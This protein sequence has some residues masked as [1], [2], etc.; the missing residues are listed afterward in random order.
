MKSIPAMVAL[1]AAA[2]FL[3]EFPF[4]LLAGFDA[5]RLRNPALLAAS[6]VLPY[7]VYSVPTGQFR[8]PAFGFLLLLALLLSYWYRVL[9]RKP[10]VDAL[11]LA[12]AA[13]VLL[14]KVFDL[15]Y[16]SPIPKV[17]F[18]TLGHLMLIRTSAIAIL[19]IRGGVN[20]EF[21]FVPTRREC[22]AGLQWFG[23]MAPVA[24]SALWA[25]GLWNLKPHPNLWTAIPQFFGILWV[26]ALSEEF[27]FWGVLSEWLTEWTG[28]GTVSLI[29]TSV[30]FGSVHLSF[31]HVFPNWRFAIVAGLLGL[32]C[33][34]CWRRTRSVQAAMVTHAIGATLYRVFFQ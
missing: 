5:G 12:L 17:P 2:A 15:V 6:C 23:L 24:L 26:V 25:L 3:I 34:L 9:P 30:L 31:A 27:F 28:H 1:P 16:P 19:A 18:S 20:A 22:R 7:L 4:Y 33:G 10:F 13:S 8:L 14:S 32:F 21:R 29:V 11:F